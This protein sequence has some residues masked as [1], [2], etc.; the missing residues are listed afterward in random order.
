MTHALDLLNQTGVRAMAMEDGMTIGMWRDLDGPEVRAALRVLG[1]DR[2]PV[3]Y[4]DGPGI[5]ARYKE[6][7]VA[8][9]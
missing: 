4:L 3:R 5:P 7:R 2:L 8:D 1:A 6:R 9:D